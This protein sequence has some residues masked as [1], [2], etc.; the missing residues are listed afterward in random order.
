MKKDNPLAKA[1]QSR[2]SMPRS[3]RTATVDLK[4]VPN[5][6]VG[7]EVE[8]SITGTVESISKSGVSI[9]ISE[10]ESDTEE[11]TNEEEVKSQ[12]QEPQV[13]RVVTQESHA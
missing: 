4:D 2:F 12:T 9:S 7:E 1:V 5:A 3:M 10:V 11:K 13:L 6:K 8:L